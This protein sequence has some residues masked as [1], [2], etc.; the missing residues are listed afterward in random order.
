MKTTAVRK[1]LGACLLG[2]LLQTVN[3]VTLVLDSTNSYTVN[4]GSGASIAQNG[5]ASGADARITF[6]GLTVF[7]G[8]VD[9]ANFSTPLFTSGVALGGQDGA[10][11]GLVG[12]F[13][14]L[15]EDATGDLFEAQVTFFRSPRGGNSGGVGI[16]P[17]IDN[18]AGLSL[19][20]NQ[21]PEPSALIL[22][23]LTP[24][25]LLRGR[26]RSVHTTT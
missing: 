10:G 16:A 24:I 20:V 13:L 15:R 18:S 4:V 17:T 6:T 25:A 12:D 7:A 19:E 5:W 1:F 9:T 8:S 14:T 23:A 26:R 21:V 2:A 11:A 22:A 3:A